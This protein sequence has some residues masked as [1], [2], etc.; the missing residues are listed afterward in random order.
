MKICRKQRSAD[1]TG[2]V[3]NSILKS[4]SRW[5]RGRWGSCTYMIELYII[6]EVEEMGQYPSEIVH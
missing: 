4:N 2:L 5:E 6:N 3:N 1:V